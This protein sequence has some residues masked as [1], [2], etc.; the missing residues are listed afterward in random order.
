MGRVRGKFQIC[1]ARFMPEML[2]GLAK[3][4]DQAFRSRG[5]EYF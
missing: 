3:F 4:K 2:Y 1:L 5:R